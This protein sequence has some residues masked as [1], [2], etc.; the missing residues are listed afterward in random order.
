E[1]LHMM[2][3]RGRRAP[4]LH[5]TVEGA[6]ASFRLLPRETTAAPALLAHLAREGV[7]R[8]DGGW[9]YRFD[10]ACNA[11]RR[12]VDAWPLLGRIAAPTLVVRGEL[13]PILPADMAERLR[14]AIPRA[15]LVEI[16]EAHHHLVLDAPAPFTA[17][18]AKFL[19]EEASTAPSEASP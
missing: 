19:S 8:R 3:A 11:S 5:A 13:S 16:P 2:H 7:I 9:Q 10:P 1:R 18:L 12:P 4:R 6:V 15:R 17:A 14:A